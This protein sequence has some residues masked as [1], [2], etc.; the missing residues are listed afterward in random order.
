MPVGEAVEI[1]LKEIY[2]NNLA[3]EIPRSAMK[4]LLKHAVTDVYLK[5]NGIWYVQSDCLAMGAL[6]AEILANVMMI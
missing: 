3:P 1:A 2:S 6:L 4:N 5:C